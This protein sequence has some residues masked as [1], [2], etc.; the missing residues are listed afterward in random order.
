MRNAITLDA[1]RVLEAIDNKG[2]FSAAAQA[3]FKVPSAITY[4]MQKLES[5][6]G[7]VLFDRSNKRAVLTPAGRLVLDEGIQLLQS[8]A[9]LEEKVHQLESGWE[10]K[11]TI[12]KD[13]IIPDAQLF[14]I[15]G[16][17]CGLNKQVEITII[18]EV[19]GGGWDAL[20]TKRADIAIGVT[21]ELPKGQFNVH[22]LGELEFVFA[23]ARH[24]PL[25]DFV[26]LIETQ[27]IKQFPTLVVADSS[28]TLPGRSSGLF[29]SKQVIRV[30]NMPSKIQAQIQGIGVG[31]LPLH[32]IKKELETGELII[33]GCAIPRPPIPVYFAVEKGRAGKALE[34]FSQE[35]KQQMWFV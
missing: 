26:G 12:A 14:E 19:L 34:W 10:A 9:R 33:K 28:R 25:A 16:R 18:E 17:F 22:A 15:L 27:H 7:V 31:F 6:L 30:S 24:H 11:L 35:L 4:T 2:S 5:D 21:G 13:T 23:V 3:L 20:Y 32:L 8:S 29:D 1:I